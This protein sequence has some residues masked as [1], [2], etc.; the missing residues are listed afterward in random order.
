M[1]MAVLGS[2]SGGNAILVKSQQTT[3]LIDAGLSAKQI[4]LR[5]QKCGVS[6]TELD[7]I[8][9][10]HEHSDHTKGLRV[11]LKGTEI[12]IYANAFTRE[13][14]QEKID[15]HLAWKVFQNGAV[16]EIGDVK[17]HSFSVPHDAQDPVGFTL[18]TP[19]AKMGVLTDTG[20]IT[21]SIV[22]SL[23]HLDALF[24]EANYDQSLL[25]ADEKRPWSIKQR[26][27][28][29]HG[30]LSNE[31]MAECVASLTPKP[32]S[33]LVLGH[34]SSDCNTQILAEEAVKRQC[35]EKNV[36]IP[37]NIYTA[38]QADPTEWIQFD[39]CLNSYV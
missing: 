16:F 37:T 36:P 25:E 29:R 7:A 23:Q 6:L 15:A 39:Q 1:Q 9:I 18:Q 34:L 22:Q 17:I 10:T 12:P 28:S 27:S 32:P 38:S 19:S 4:K 31:Q 11:L 35:K 33:R 24:I 13:Y 5:M 21:Q 8:L 30:H 2:G 26:I 20:Y 3:L 14:L